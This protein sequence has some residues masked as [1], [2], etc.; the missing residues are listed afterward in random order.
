MTDSD[1]AAAL[2][3][4]IP[5]SLWSQGSTDVGLCNVTP[6]T[7]TADYSHPINVP[8]Y[9]RPQHEWLGITDTITGLLQSGV[10]E[11]ASDNVW[12]TPLLPVRKPTSAYRIV[13]NLRLINHVIKDQTVP[14]SNPF[15]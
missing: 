1:A 7:I 13:H 2:L 9:P 10:L 3:Q 5:D 11:P 4:S 15:V 14:V 12:N 8:Q 6:V